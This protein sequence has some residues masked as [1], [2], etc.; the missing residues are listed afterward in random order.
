MKKNSGE[1]YS[2]LTEYE[3]GKGRV[4]LH[5]RNNQKP[6]KHREDLMHLSAQG[7]SSVVAP[8]V[9]F[10]MA[11]IMTISSTRG[12]YLI[13]S[14]ILK[15]QTSYLPGSKNPHVSSTWFEAGAPP[16][17]GLSMSEGCRLGVCKSH[18]HAWRGLWWVTEKAT[19]RTEGPVVS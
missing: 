15:T 8:S 5:L 1:C 13:I 18:V 17:D 6:A 14:T 10:H 16:K 19:L 4:Q 7:H 9:F 3:H 2:L 12:F 11:E